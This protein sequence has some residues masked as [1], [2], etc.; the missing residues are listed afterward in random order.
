VFVREIPNPTLD[1]SPHSRWHG[2]SAAVSTAVP[3]IESVAVPVAACCSVRQ[4]N[5]YTHLNVVK[6][7]AHVV[8]SKGANL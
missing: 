6:M 4:A 1:A 7:P 8:S 2:S 3:V 5:M